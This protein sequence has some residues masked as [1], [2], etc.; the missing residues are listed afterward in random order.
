M[1]LHLHLLTHAWVARAVRLPAVLVVQRLSSV[2]AFAMYSPFSR[3]ARSATGALRR[4]WGTAG[5]ARAVPPWYSSRW[6]CLRR[7]ES[8]FT[9]HVMVYRTVMSAVMP[10]RGRASTAPAGVAHV[11]RER[12]GRG[13]PTSYFRL[14]S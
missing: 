12:S 4:H 6:P 7:T 3:R 1:T 9:S 2:R 8:V 14:Q 5:A 11:T 13:D 10:A